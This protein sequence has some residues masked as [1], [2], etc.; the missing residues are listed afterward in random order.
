MRKFI[1]IVVATTIFVVCFQK[2]FDIGSES[3]KNTIQESAFKK[4]A[5]TWMN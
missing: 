4:E 1:I 3:V 5:V 2:G